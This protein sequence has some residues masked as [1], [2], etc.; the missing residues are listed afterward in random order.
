M[1]QNI[2]QLNKYA[3]EKVNEYLHLDIAGKKVPTP[4][5]INRIEF[6]F[7][8]LMEMAGVS[9]EKIEQVKKLYR[10]RKVPYGW[11]RGKGA[12]EEIKSALLELAEH[13]NEPLELMDVEGVTHFMKSVGLGVDC[14]GMVYNV[15]NTVFERVGK[16]EEFNKSLDWFTESKTVYQAKS[17]V[18]AGNASEIISDLNSIRSLDLILKKNDSDYTHVALIL[19][20]GDGWRIVHS[21]NKALPDGVRIDLLKIANGQPEFVIKNGIG[22][23]WQTFYEV[24]QIEFRRL[25]C[26]N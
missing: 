26:I 23:S 17:N 12:P 7:K 20:D 8:E 9:I 11:Y 14:S 24:G 10:E 15:L 2:D 3:W 21:T 18:F 19:A 16:T 5:F 22:R 4:Y 6:Y 1:T 13:T 25:K